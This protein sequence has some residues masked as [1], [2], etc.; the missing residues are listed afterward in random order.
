M[1]LGV[2]P[3]NAANTILAVDSGTHYRVFS[4]VESTTNIALN[5]NFNAWGVAPGGTITAEEVSKVQL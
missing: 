5:L 3:Q 2:T 4:I 1:S